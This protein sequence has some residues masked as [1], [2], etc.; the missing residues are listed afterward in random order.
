MTGTVF[1]IKEFAINDGPGVR[2]TVFLKGCPLRCAWCHNPEGQ[3]PRPE[4]NLLT[5]RIVGREWSVDELVNHCAKFADCWKEGEG[6]V[7]FSGGEPTMQA[8]FLMSAARGLRSRGVHVTLETCGHC[9]ANL[10]EKVLSCMDLV[11]Y[12]LKC[13]DVTVHKQMTGVD[14]ALIW[15]NLKALAASG[16]PYRVRVPLVPGVSDS[17]ENRRE[18]ERFVAGLVCQPDKIEWLPFN[19]L[20]PGKYPA[21]GR[22]WGRELRVEG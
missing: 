4:K 15:A 2:V 13:M 14:T 5:G 22:V 9:E 3:D 21:Y 20:A 8:A 11:Y 17:A 6:G 18:T 10:F 19:E 12:D 16:V 7:T 1:D